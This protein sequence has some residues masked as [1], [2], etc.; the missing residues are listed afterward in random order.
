MDG[1]RRGV[2]LLRHPSRAFGGAAFAPILIVVAH[3][4]L[5]N[6]DSSGFGVILPEIRDHFDLDVATTSSIAGITTVAG[7]V[8]SLPVATWSDRRARRTI[9]LAVGALLAAAF[10][11][12]AG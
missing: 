9:F 8:L 2:Q 4:L 3:T 11:V 12:M 1:I 5:D 6:I 7:I 10:S